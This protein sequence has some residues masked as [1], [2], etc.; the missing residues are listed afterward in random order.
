[1][2]LQEFKW[3]EVLQASEPVLVDFWASWCS[4]CRAMNPTI[5]APARDFKACKVN[6]DTN[7]ELAGHY[8]ISSIP[9]LLIFKNGKVVARHVGVTPE[10]TLR[11]ELEQWS[12][13]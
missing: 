13:S 5:E 3:K 8:G 9:V 6:V 4:P 7:H 1:M 2:L 12:Q 11:A 10:A